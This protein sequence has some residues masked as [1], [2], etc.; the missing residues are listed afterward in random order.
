M[1]S[2]IRKLSDHL[3]SLDVAAKRSKLQNWRQAMINDDAAL[4]AWLKSK[5]SP[6]GAFVQTPSGSIA[7]TQSEAAQVVFDYWTDF[8]RKSE[9]ECPSV[10]ARCRSITDGMQDG[11]PL[12]WGAP[13]GAQLLQRAQKCRG[14]GGP[15]CW[16]GSELRYLPPV[17]FDMFSSHGSRWLQAGSVPEQFSESR[18]VLLPKEGKVNEQ[19][20][21]QVEHLRPITILSIWWR[22]WMSTL[23]QTPEVKAWVSQHVPSEFAVGHNIPT[24]RVAFE[25]LDCFCRDKGLLTLAYS[26]AFDRL[27]SSL[28]VSLCSRKLS[29]CLVLFSRGFMSTT[30][31]L[32]HLLLKPLPITLTTGRLGRPKL[33]LSKIRRKLV[34]LGEAK[35]WLIG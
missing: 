4:G 35:T 31:R 25:L 2:E 17:I 10:E 23:L 8:W 12:V 9:A 18:M 3:N 20:V 21:I 1:E 26:K 16:T 15:D 19:N 24:E 11:D 7:L 33:V 28:G 27:R 22:L 29:R 34:L 32:S 13:T 14:A 5:T 6:M 30:G